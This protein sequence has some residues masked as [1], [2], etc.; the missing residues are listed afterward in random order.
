M[1]FISSDQP[2]AVLYQVLLSKLQ[3]NET[4]QR[5][6]LSCAHCHSG[7]LSNKL[8]CLWDIIFVIY[9]YSSMFV[10]NYLHSVQKAS[11]YWACV[12]LKFHFWALHTIFLLLLVTL[13]Y[14][15]MAISLRTA[16]EFHTFLSDSIIL[17]LVWIL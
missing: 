12:C 10:L 16:T 8:S 4:F 11:I 2:M 17:Q 7:R 9:F 6:V 13:I 5:H 1:F 3:D 15:A 14:V